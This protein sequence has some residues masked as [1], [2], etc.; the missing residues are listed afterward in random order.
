M[1]RTRASRYARFLRRSASSR[2]LDAFFTTD[3]LSQ[4]PF[5]KDPGCG[6][7]LWG[8]RAGRSGPRRPTARAARLLGLRSGRL[9]GPPGTAPPGAP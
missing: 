3:L 7:G 9:Y 2:P 1:A 5:P 8:V 4:T 6:R